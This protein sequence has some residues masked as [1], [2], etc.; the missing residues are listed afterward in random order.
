MRRTLLLAPA[1]IALTIACAGVALGSSLQGSVIRA[2]TGAPISS[3]L[4]EAY[5][6]PA[7]SLEAIVRTDANGDFLISDLQAGR[8]HLI[9]HAAPLLDTIIQGISLG[10]SDNFKVPL[11]LTME[12][13]YIQF[14]PSGMR[15]DPKHQ[16]RVRGVVMRASTDQ[17][18]R[19]TIHPL[20]GAQV[21]V[22]RLWGNSSSGSATTD[23]AGAFAIGLLTPGSYTLRV[24]G[25]DDTVS[26][27]LLPGSNVLVARPFIVADGRY[28]DIYRLEVPDRCG[29]LV[30]PQQTSDVYVV[31]GESLTTNP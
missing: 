23:S 4:V 8:Y 22:V 2:D 10:A 15:F 28:E 12:L 21:S 3:A 30:E 19:T 25:T 17:D 7:G 11:P 18:G 13:A 5:L 6:E 14:I 31:C 20:Q 1:V 24:E 29:R 9:L 27:D 16:A 26:L